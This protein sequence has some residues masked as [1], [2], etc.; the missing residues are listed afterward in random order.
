MFLL[1][2]GSA[3]CSDVVLSLGQLLLQLVNRSGVENLQ[4]SQCVSD[5]LDLRII[6]SQTVD[7]VKHE[8]NAEGDVSSSLVV[9]YAE[10]LVSILVGNEELLNERSR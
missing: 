4:G 9:E 10:E 5:R 8:D 2:E 3:S 7:S 6:L 1:D